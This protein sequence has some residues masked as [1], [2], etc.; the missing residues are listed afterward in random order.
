MLDRVLFYTFAGTAVLSA[1]AVITRRN[2]IHSA[3]Y[4][5]ITVL[6]TGG[7]FLQLRAEFLFATQIV[8]YAGGVVALLILVI[9]FLRQDE[10]SSPMRLGMWEGAAVLT[11]LA[12]G[13]LAA[14]ML[15]WAGKLPGGG[16]FIPKIED[17]EK[18]PPNAEELAKGLFGTYLLAFEITGVLLLVAMVGAVLMANDGESGGKT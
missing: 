10:V 8:I 13:L 18:L 4:L 15:L 14:G 9:M 3:V 1:L 12:L 2:A 7:I 6:A 16:L 17:A 5:L 11:A